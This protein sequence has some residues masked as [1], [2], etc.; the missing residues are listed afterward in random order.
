MPAVCSAAPVGVNL[1]G[2]L[3]MVTTDESTTTF[4]EYDAIGRVRRSTQGMTQAAGL[5][6]SFEYEWNHVGLTA[7][8]Y[9]SGRRVTYGYDTGDRFLPSPTG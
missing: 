2:R 7:I 5:P 4:G 6:W 1:L 9:P 3:T 8:R